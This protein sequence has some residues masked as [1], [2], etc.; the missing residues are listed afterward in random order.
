MQSLQPKLGSTVSCDL[1][2][3]N[4]SGNAG[5]VDMGDARQVN[6]HCPRMWRVQQLEKPVAHCWRGIDINAAL[7]RRQSAILGVHDIDFRLIDALSVSVQRQR[8]LLG[9]ISQASYGQPPRSTRECC[10]QE[11]GHHR[12]SDNRRKLKYLRRRGDTDYERC[13]HYQGSRARI[14]AD[15]VSYAWIL[16]LLGQGAARGGCFLPSRNHGPRG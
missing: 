4:Q 16:T 13:R 9:V 12:P 10:W 14:R 2:R 1:Y 7:Q 6:A 8:F 5:T 11:H 15:E 3:F